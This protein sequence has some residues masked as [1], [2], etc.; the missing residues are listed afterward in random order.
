MIHHHCYGP[1]PQAS[2]ACLKLP[3]H[4][5]WL[6]S[7]STRLHRLRNFEIGKL[8]ALETSL[9]ASSVAESLQVQDARM[10]LHND[11]H[12]RVSCTKAEVRVFAVCRAVVGVETT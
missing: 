9:G 6:F 11:S 3:T 5:N 1:S 12:A 4:I 10:R 7:S 8:E 2:V